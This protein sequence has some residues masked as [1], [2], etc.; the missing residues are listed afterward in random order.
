[1]G[2]V[3]D[4]CKRKSAS[5]LPNLIKMHRTQLIYTLF[6]LILI[7]ITYC[8]GYFIT[9]DANDEECFYDRVKKGTKMGL[10]FEVAEGGSLD[11]DVTIEGPDG[12]EIHSGQ[13]E[14]NGKYTFAS[15][16]DGVYK[17]CFSNEMSTTTPKV[18]MFNMEIGDEPSEGEGEEEV[19]HNKLE[20]QVK[21]LGQ[22]IAG[23]KHEQEYMEVRDRIH[24][25]INDNTNTRVVMW[26]FFE[27]CVLVAMTVG[28]VYYLKRFFEVR[29]VV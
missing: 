19:D 1:M 10:I 22:A 3:A 23:A 12:K 4:W 7:A 5:S 17:Y 29:R 28:Q 15:H 25:A 20:E 18:V 13:R 6:L 9:I 8:Q 24:R 14:S 27:A 21:E 11:I 26:S 16:L 2:V